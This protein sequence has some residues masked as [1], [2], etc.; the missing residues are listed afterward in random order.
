MT[1]RNQRAI[2]EVGTLES[3]ATLEFLG[4]GDLLGATWATLAPAVKAKLQELQPGQVLLV[5][6]DDPLARLDAPA[7]CALTGNVLE[8]TGVEE[9]GIIRFFI[10]KEIKRR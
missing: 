10:R 3:A 7:W 6:L 5:S 9:G 8:A 4:I 1:D 2:L